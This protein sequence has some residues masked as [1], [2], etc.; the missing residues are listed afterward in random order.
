MP[1]LC[2]QFT[3]ETPSKVTAGPASGPHAF[4]ER[5]QV[6]LRDEMVWGT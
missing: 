4:M 3:E 6:S 1:R 5:V 2:V